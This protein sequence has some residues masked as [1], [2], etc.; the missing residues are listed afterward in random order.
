MLFKELNDL[1]KKNTFN[2][3]L[4]PRFVKFRIKKLHTLVF[5]LRA[6]IKIF[7]Y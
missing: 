6:Q 3:K 5:L 7:Y 2:K 1:H 4:I